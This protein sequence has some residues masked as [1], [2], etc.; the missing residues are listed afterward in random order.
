MIFGEKQRDSVDIYLEEA[1]DNLG[2]Y[3]YYLER[4]K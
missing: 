1:Q 4:E 2:Y 3:E